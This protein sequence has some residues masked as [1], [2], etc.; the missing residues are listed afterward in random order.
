VVAVQYYA[1]DA[2]WA[3]LWWVVGIEGHV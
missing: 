1:C 3:E 2:K